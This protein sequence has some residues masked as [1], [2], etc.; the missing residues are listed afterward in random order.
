MLGLLKFKCR[1]YLLLLGIL[2]ILSSCSRGFVES[3]N[4]GFALGTTYS[5][6]FYDSVARDLQKEID[7]V[8]ARIN[9]SMSTYDL[10]SDIS[11]IN[12]G[13]TTVV[14]DKMFQE[15]F[16]L[17][18]EVYENT[19]GYFDPTVGVLINS[20]GFG[21]GKQIALD[22]LKVDSLLAYVGFN[23][24]RLKEDFTIAKKNIN[25]LFD[26]NAVAKGYA[27]D[28]LG[29]LLDQVGIENYL[30]EVGGE[31]IAKGENKIKGKPFVV[32]I[33][34]PQGMD[35]S[36]PAVKIHL[37]NKALASSGNYRHFRIDSITG[38]ILVHTVD[39]TTGYTKKS[40]VLGVSVLANTC[41][42][43]DAYATS[44]MAMDMEDAL[45]LLSKKTAIQAYF[46]YLDMNGETRHFTTDKFSKIVLKP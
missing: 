8:F 2:L 28:R 22:S 44:F 13:D 29:V 7:S 41:A 31:L 1:K 5:I 43:A 40:N 10:D 12:A 42:E 46:I 17:S 25:I 30:I 32:G 27:V 39:P 23:K 3:R 34:D 24:V 19:N 26:F 45:K 11:K 14:V 18:K 38:K 9:H 33:D 36:V 6:L 20:W 21:P 4:S 16:M 15:V 35:R 37:E